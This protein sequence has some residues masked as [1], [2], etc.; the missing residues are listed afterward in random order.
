MRMIF[1]REAEGT[2]QDLVR[3]IPWHSPDGMLALEIPEGFVDM[4]EHRKEENYPSSDRPKIILEH[5]EE[6]V[7]ITLQLFGRKMKAEET[8][9]AVRE[10]RRTVENIFVQ[11]RLSPAHLANG[12]ET[13]AGWFLMKMKDIKKEH[14]KAVF[15][16]KEHMVLFT[17]TYP[18]GE[19]AKWRIVTEMILKS[20]KEGKGSG[21]GGT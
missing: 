20:V 6:E 17:V 3:M 10:V 12:R 21:A 18:E 7:Q 16:I 19:R 11:Y 5:G 2:A 4:E 8:E 9:A 1:D 13:T 14:I 15:S